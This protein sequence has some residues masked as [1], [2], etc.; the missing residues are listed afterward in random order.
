MLLVKTP[1]ITP[2]VECKTAGYRLFEGSQG[3]AY[4]REW[5]ACASDAGHR[6]RSL[7]LSIGVGHRR[8]YRITPGV[9]CNVTG[10]RDVGAEGEAITVTFGAG[11]NGLAVERPELRRPHPSCRV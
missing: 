10:C 3:F 2:G 5:V 6:R 4:R 8:R 1:A 9:E 7:S 11:P